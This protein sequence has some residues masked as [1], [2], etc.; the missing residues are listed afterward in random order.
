MRYNIIVFAIEKRV[1]PNEP[2][3]LKVFEN[4]AGLSIISRVG[5]SDEEIRIWN[6][7][8]I[9]TRAQSDNGPQVDFST[10]AKRRSDKAE[11]R[12]VV[13]TAN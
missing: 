6:K 2:F 7:V 12:L 4:N 3:L 11:H 5:S 9:Q 1:G 10:L 8:L 13:F